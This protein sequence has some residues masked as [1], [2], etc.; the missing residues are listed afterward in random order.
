[1]YSCI[2]SYLCRVFRL[3]EFRFTRHPPREPMI[4]LS[5][6]IYVNFF[7][8]HYWPDLRL[9]LFAAAAMLF[10]RTTVYF[11]IWRRHR[12]MPLLLG[13]SLVA[14]FIWISENV[15]TFTRVWLYPAQ[16]HGW[17]MVP[18]GKFGA[19]FLLL[20]ISYTLV[21][22]IA[23]PRDRLLSGHHDGGA[24]RG[25][26][27]GDDEAEQQQAKRGR[28]RAVG[29]DQIPQAA[30]IEHQQ[31]GDQEQRQRDPGRQIDRQQA[32][33]RQVQPGPSVRRLPAAGSVLGHRSLDLDEVACQPNGARLTLPR[34]SR[35]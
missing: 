8:H 13:L 11:K 6:A 25:R 32:E 20:I 29:P 23:A 12:A 7:T 4:A 27:E 9:G 19:W 3:F 1:M 5:M 2:G 14:L 18:F 26:A 31:A 16:Q 15:G 34:R 22:L 33:Q 17:V 21:C 24:H 30:G 28:R 35:F 10:G